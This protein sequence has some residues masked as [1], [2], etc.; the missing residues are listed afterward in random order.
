MLE[1]SSAKHGYVLLLRIPDGRLPV[2][3]M[4]CMFGHHGDYLRC[5]ARLELAVQEV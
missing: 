3:Y 5:S 4:G 2:V 1:A